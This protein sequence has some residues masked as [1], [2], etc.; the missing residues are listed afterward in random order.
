MSGK[1]SIRL[2]LA[3]LLT[4]F[5]AAAFAQAYPSRTVRIV[6]PFPPGGPT[7]AVG[8][9]LAQKLSE[10]TGQSF[11]IENRAGGNGTI[12]PNEVIKSPRDGYTLLFNASTFV[13]TPLTSKS[14]TYDVQKDFAPIALVAKGPLAVSVSN[15][16]PVKD[17]R[18]LMA[19]AKA[20]PGKL[21]FAVGST[22]SAGHLATELLRRSAGLDFLIVPY[23]GSTPAYQDLIGGQI[24]GFV[25]PALGALPYWK[26]NRIKVLAVTS[27]QRL[28]SAPQTP[29]VAETVRGFEFY[30][31]Y[32]LWGPSGLPAEVVAKLNAEVNKALNSDLKDRLLQLGYEFSV[33]TPDDFARFQREDITR[34]AK[35]VVESG[36][37]A[38]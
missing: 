11:I 10:Q 22:G 1:W 30:S 6:L 12:G 17:I 27:T 31:W 9:M 26:G 24:Q 14:V 23:K 20:N 13:L 37:T 35:I 38:E 5:C 29:T 28:P 19:Y 33:G 2:F 15:E 3:A 34:S 21:A 16:L 18:E 32:G 25:D 7:D 36:I 8:R 4:A